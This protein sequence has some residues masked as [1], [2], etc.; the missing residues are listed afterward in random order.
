[1][2]MAPNTAPQS[3]L[4]SISSYPSKATVGIKATKIEL[5]N[6]SCI[7]EDKNSIDEKPALNRNL[8]TTESDIK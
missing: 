1:M 2:V 8:T 5:E 6:K 4:T 7:E 3:L